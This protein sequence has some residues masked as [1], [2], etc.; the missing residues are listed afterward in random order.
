MTHCLD[1]QLR[2]AYCI[3]LASSVLIPSQYHADSGGS[4]EIVRQ[5]GEVEGGSLMQMSPLYPSNT[6]WVADYDPITSL[7]DANWTVPTVMRSCEKT[8]S[9]FILFFPPDFI[10][11]VVLKSRF[12]L[13]MFP[14][15]C[16]WLPP[17]PHP[18]LST[19]A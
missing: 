14:F 13:S 12:R 18:P 3:I 15:A 17:L 10:R 11:Y 8:L 9:R 7:G 4:F 6:D 16:K 1:S 2:Y 19:K 5:Q